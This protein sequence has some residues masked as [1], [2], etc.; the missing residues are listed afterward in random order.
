MSFETTIHAEEKRGPIL[1]REETWTMEGNPP[2]RMKNAYNLA[3]DY[4]GDESFGKCLLDMG[5]APEKRTPSSSVCSIGF[6]EYSQMW[7]GWSHRAICGFAV[8]SEAKE[9]DC[10]CSPGSCDPR[11]DVSV[12]PGFVAKTLDDAK[13]MAIAFAE[14]VS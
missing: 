3:G 4:V 5:L 10:M 8:G 1:F 6:S 11:Q 14:S 2:T 13:R 9:G 12:P 7:F